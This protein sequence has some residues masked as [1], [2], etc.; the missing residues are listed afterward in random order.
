MKADN[1]V[2]LAA[3]TSSRFAPLSQERP[4]GLTEVR[5]EV[6]IER[7]IRQLREAGVQ[8]IYAVTGYMAE[9]FAYLER[10]FG[11]R[12]IH[13]PDYLQRN[14]NGSIYAARHVLGNTLI[15][16]ADNYFVGNP[17]PADCGDTAWYAAE[18][19]AGPT[20][21]WCMTEKDGIIDSVTVGGRDAWIML[22]H[23]FWTETFSR[24][25]LK[26]LEAEYADVA[27]QLWEHI[28]IRHLRE[29]PM[30][31]RKYPPGFILEF[32]TL[33][34]LRGFDSSYV[35][36]TRSAILKDIAAR[37]GARE[38]EMKDFQPIRGTGARAEGFTFL[39]QGQRFRYMY[40]TAK[41]E[42]WM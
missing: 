31:I 1:A 28:F 32:D 2:I 26:I 34:E 18:Y 39:W 17:F 9:A 6:L 25:F 4:K 14:N 27:D 40:A 10:D 8:E 41:T 7:Q 42:R 21:E 23:V 5:G 38:A 12:L 37:L 13:N 29:L 22:G 20:E 19:A 24:R 36:D 35:E 33:D 30:A 11:V 15:C 3:G 16:S